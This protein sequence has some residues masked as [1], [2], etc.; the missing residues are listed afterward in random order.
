MP[1]LNSMNVEFDNELLLLI[2]ENIDSNSAA[3]GT[4]GVWSSAISQALQSP[5]RLCEAKLAF[6]NERDRS[7]WN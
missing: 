1:R 3:L 4:N 2:V 7:K 6:L 5:S